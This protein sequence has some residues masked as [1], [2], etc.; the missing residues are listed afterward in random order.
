MKMFLFPP[1]HKSY[2]KSVSKFFK[3]GYFKRARN[4]RTSTDAEKM[5]YKL[6]KIGVWSA[7]LKFAG[8]PN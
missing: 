5:L 4:I 7:K 2:S 8:R 3:L 1:F 6:L